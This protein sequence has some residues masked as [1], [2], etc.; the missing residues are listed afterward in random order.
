MFCSTREINDEPLCHAQLVSEAG[1]WS[2]DSWAIVRSQLQRTAG[3]AQEQ[4]IGARHVCEL[5]EKFVN[6]NNTLFKD[7]LT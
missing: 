4:T 3:A 7:W 2:S 1:E 6:F 5:S